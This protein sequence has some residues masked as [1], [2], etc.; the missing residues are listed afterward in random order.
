MPSRINVT[1]DDEYAAKL[2][3]LADRAHIQEGT[4]AKA[5]LSTALDGADPEAAHVVALL[6]GIAGARAAAAE[7]LAQARRGEGIALD[8]LASARR[9]D[10]LD[11][12]A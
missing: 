6:D 5:L 10:A 1:L 9:P 2:R 12:V 11:D 7:G 3:N 8:D 4:L